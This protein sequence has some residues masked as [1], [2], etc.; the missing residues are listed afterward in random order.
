M[1]KWM[2]QESASSADLKKQGFC[3]KDMDLGME[4]L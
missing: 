2:L 4:M 3:C 1:L